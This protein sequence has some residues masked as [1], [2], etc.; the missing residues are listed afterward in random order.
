M[1]KTLLVGIA[2]LFS[3][4]VFAVTEHYVL[5]DGNHVYHLKV[6]ETAKEYSISADVN[7]EPNADEKGKRACSA[8]IAGEARLMDKD[9]LILKKHA[10]SGAT[11]CKLK[12]HL[13]E[14]GAKIEQLNSCN[15]FATGICHFSTNGKELVKVK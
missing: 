4:S 2:M 9:K 7:F 13:S 12:I 8:S 6:V 15:N 3:S 5:R 1:K 11:Y 14:T 10:E